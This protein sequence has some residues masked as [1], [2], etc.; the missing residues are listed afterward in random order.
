MAA[1][2]R[3][4]LKDTGRRVQVGSAEPAGRLDDKQRGCKRAFSHRLK[5]VAQ[6]QWGQ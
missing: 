3:A 2:A 4:M 6:S 1:R 5:R